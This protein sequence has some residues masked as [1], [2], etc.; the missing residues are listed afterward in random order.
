MKPAKN[1]KEF[2][3]L[4]KSK[5]FR[6]SY[7]AANNTR[8]FLALFKGS[9]LFPPFLPFYTFSS[10]NLQPIQPLN[11]K[12]NPKQALN[13]NRLPIDLPYYLYKNSTTKRATKKLPS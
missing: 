10:R 6:F 8:S 2:K 12:N 1:K 9:S 13:Q 3:P 7:Q 11:Q 4:T 5:S